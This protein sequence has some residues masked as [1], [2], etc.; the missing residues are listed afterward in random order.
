MLGPSVDFARYFDTPAAVVSDAV[1]PSVP[2]FNARSTPDSERAS[3]AEPL[4]PIPSA[5]QVPSTAAAPEPSTED[6][7]S[8]DRIPVRLRGGRRAWLLIPPVFYESD[9]AR[10]KAQIDLLRTEDDESL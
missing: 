1:E 6:T 8:H 2:A 3:V 5:Q 9:K 10:M 7:L 4:S